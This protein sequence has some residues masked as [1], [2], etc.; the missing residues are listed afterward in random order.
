MSQA[1]LLRVSG[2]WLIVKLNCTFTVL[3][4]EP[5]TVEFSDA[6]QENREDRDL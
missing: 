6:I 4:G 5:P 2:G 1:A 3:S